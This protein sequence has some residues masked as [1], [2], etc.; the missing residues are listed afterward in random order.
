MHRG[1]ASHT[2]TTAGRYR[3]D[4]SLWS[5][6]ALLVVFVMLR[7]GVPATAHAERTALE[8]ASLSWVRLPGAEKCAGAHTLARVVE[9]RLGRPVFVAAAEAHH[10]V[11]GY[12]RP[13]PQGGWQAHLSVRNDAGEVLGQR[14]LHVR[15]EDCTVLTEP[16]TLVIALTLYP[17]ASAMIATITEDDFDWDTW[18][19][20]HHDAARTES[21]EP[22]RDQPHQPE[23]P[24]KARPSAAPAPDDEPGQPAPL[25]RTEPSV[26]RQYD[27]GK[28]PKLASRGAPL[29]LYA[30]GVV[31]YGQLPSFTPGAVVAI[32]LEPEDAWALELAGRL[33]AHSEARAE[34]QGRAN[35]QLMEIRG[36]IC[37][38]VWPWGNAMRL[39]GCAGLL[40]GVMQA[41]AR[42]FESANGT[43]AH[44]MAGPELLARWELE[45]LPWLT[46]RAAAS[47][48]VPLTRPRFTYI[49]EFGH[50]QELFEVA[51][52]LTSLELGLGAHFR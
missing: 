31:G 8:S 13:H 6:L 43:M 37:P 38:L 48:S 34:R 18:A 42:E 7:V 3:H 23:P 14:D 1:H 36:A 45:I 52:V 44:L 12:V 24:E 29:T 46:V 9:H 50:D 49:N 40:L 35:L 27:G 41:Q 21:P 32:A 25:R 22:S 26:L 30:G 33:W 16:L 10:L 5:G 15:G 19:A 4:C 47:A 39:T 28:S 2:I 20:E 51:P 17:D 11:E